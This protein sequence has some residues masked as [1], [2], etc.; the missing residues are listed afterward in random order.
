MPFSK[1]QLP[2]TAAGGSP[3]SSG[4]PDWGIISFGLGRDFASANKLF[5]DRV[6]DEGNENWLDFSQLYFRFS[7]NDSG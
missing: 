5:D 4:G 7:V 2:L 3:E 1:L 6:G